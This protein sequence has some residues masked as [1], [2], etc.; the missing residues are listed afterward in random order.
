MIGEWNRYGVRYR[1]GWGEV[2]VH[3]S[4]ALHYLFRKSRLKKVE[5]R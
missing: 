3:T 5:K 2:P 4:I 1:G